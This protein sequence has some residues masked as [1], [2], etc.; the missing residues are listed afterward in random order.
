MV[1]G[2]RCCENCIFLNMREK[3]LSSHGHNYRYGCVK[4]SDGYLPF[5]LC[6]NRND[7]ELRTGGCGDFQKKLECGMLYDFYTQDN[8]YRIMYCGKTEQKYLIYNQTLKV[9]KLVSKLWYRNHRKEIIVIPYKDDELV[10]AEDKRKFRKKL[11]RVKKERYI[12]EHG[13]DRN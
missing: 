2:L 4:S 6:D 10:S 9:Y 7:I 12:K 8:K 5:W 1:K 13:C 11:A 3:E